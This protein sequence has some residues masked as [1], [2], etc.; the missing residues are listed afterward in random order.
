MNTSET[1]SDMI[2]TNYTNILNLMTDQEYNF[3]ARKLGLIEIETSEGETRSETS[4][5]GEPGE[6]PEHVDFDAEEMATFFEELM[7]DVNNSID[8]LYC[9]C[10]YIDTETSQE[11]L[12]EPSVVCMG[13][14]PEEKMKCAL[15]PNSDF[16]FGINLL[17]NLFRLLNTDKNDVKRLIDDFLVK[18]PNLEASQL[19]TLFGCHQMKTAM[20]GLLISVS[21][22]EGI[23]TWYFFSEEY[24]S[25]FVCFFVENFLVSFYE[26]LYQTISEVQDEVC[27]CV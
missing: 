3:L 6:E 13:T 25:G 23:Q 15:N 5:E 16:S 26:T 14:T 21:V 1:L 4:S 9:T 12:I 8:I 27:D 18:V 19:A 10:D 24:P 2:I 7:H 20:F 11:E 17:K 22:L